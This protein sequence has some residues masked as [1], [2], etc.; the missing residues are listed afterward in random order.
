MDNP[1]ENIL[2]DASSNV[3]VRPF[4]VGAALR[5]A[6]ERLG[7]SVADV[8]SRLKF[9][10]RQIE[11][12]ETDNFTRL[13]EIF[14]VRRFVRSYAKLLQLDPNPLLAALPIAPVQPSLHA[15]SIAIEVPFPNTYATRR[16]KIIWLAIGLV[17]VA[18]TLI[19]FVWLNRS[20]PIMPQATVETME[21][22]GV[23]TPASEVVAVPSPDVLVAPP[24]A[25]VA[26]K[27]IKIESNSASK[28][29]A[30]IRL[31]FDADSWVKVMD[32]DGK[33][34][35]SQLNSSGSEQHLK[36]KPPFSVVIGNV[37]GV[38]LYYQGKLVELA[39]FNNGGTARLTLE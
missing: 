33:I 15:A 38:R 31:T 28:Q 3:D 20:K 34:L 22:P 27:A 9:A 18:I 10:S 2:N 39:P 11:A 26:A 8:E 13:P 37:N 4:S 5:E 36:G 29:S 35:L 30:S 17:A 16:L 21:L 6:R 24:E 32:N 25:P 14:F 1:S 23:P 12:L 7:L 19:L